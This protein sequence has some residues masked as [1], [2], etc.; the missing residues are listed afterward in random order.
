MKIFAEEECAKDD[1]NINFRSHLTVGHLSIDEFDQLV[2]EYSD[3]INF[4]FTLDKIYFISR[5]DSSSPFS[6]SSSISLSTN[7]IPD[8]VNNNNNLDN[9]PKNSKNKKIKN[10]N[11]N[12]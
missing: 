8:I 7:Y 11:N 10:N 4:E 3:Q 12:K 9:H 6:V 5:E 2:E 1:H